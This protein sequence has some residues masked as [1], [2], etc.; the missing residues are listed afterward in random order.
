MSLCLLHGKACSRKLQAAFIM[1][2]MCWPL[3][4]T[5]VRGDGAKHSFIRQPSPSDCHYSAGEEKTM[6][7]PASA[8]RRY[9]PIHTR[10]HMT[11]TSHHNTWSPQQKHRAD[12]NGVERG[13]PLEKLSSGGR[14]RQL[15]VYTASPL[16]PLPPVVH[17]REIVG[18][19]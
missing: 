8:L 12:D 18:G 9:H 6:T 2:T 16:P 1:G 5:H 14:Q 7:S 11:H 19:I 13:V 10:T 15:V 4:S 17:S 3:N